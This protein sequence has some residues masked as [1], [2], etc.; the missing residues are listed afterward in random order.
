MARAAHNGQI[1][2]LCLLCTDWALNLSDVQGFTPS[3]RTKERNGCS[4]Q[5]HYRL[6]EASASGEPI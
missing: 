6:A 3:V 2:S 4:H 1:R 5:K